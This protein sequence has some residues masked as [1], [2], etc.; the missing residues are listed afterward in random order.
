M[1]AVTAAVAVGA[2]MAYAANRQGA[3]AKAAGRAQGNAASDAMAKYDDVYNQ[4][5]QD[6]SGWLTTGQQANSRL[7]ALMNGDFSSFQVDPSYQWQQ[8]QGLQG[9][10]R[11]A[12]ARGNYRGGA[13]DA[14][15]LRF[16]QGLASQEYGKFFDRNMALSN[17]GLGTAQYLGQLGQNYA[18]NWAR[19]RGVKGEADAQ[20]AAAGPMTQAGYGNAIASAFSTYAGMGGGGGGGGF[21]GFDFSKMG[22]GQQR[23]NSFSSLFSGQ[24]NTGPGSIYNFGNNQDNLWGWKG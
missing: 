11:L 9:L 13:T 22:G 21:G 14:D 24:A 8:E 7:Q 23:G 3:A 15:I 2:G 5:R 19:A 10:S 1:A 4:G 6:A 16:N 20:R 18:Q 17:Q 12:A